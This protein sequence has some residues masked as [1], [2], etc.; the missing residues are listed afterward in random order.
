MTIQQIKIY[1]KKHFFLVFRYNNE[2]YTLK[3]SR[4][5]FCLRYSLIAT[6]TLPHCR[7]SLEE[8]CE[9]TYISNSTLLVEA[10]KR[11]EIP[12]QDDPSWRTYEAVRHSAIVNRNEI[13][14]S[15][16]QRNYWIAH[17]DEGLSH[18]SDDLGNTQ[19]FN[20]C[21]D[22]FENA[23]ID[24]RTLEGIWGKVVVDAC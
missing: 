2:Y 21:R 5:L 11:M 20:S 24:G 22:L 4:S 6:D 7:N 3:R 12:K 8:L 16:N 9:Q 13:H 18:L 15:Y 23:R 19:R 17:T 10:I 1:L 14:F